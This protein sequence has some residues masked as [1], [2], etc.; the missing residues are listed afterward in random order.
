M[1]GG[2]KRRLKLLSV[3]LCFHLEATGVLSLSL[4]QGIDMSNFVFRE[5]PSDAV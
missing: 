5:D 1:S 3:A 2:R 4:S